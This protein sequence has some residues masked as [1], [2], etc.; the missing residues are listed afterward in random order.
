M[1]PE[2]GQ[3]LAEVKNEPGDEADTADH[4]RATLPQPADQQLSV[5]AN[6]L[7]SPSQLSED[8]N[9][10]QPDRDQSSFANFESAWIMVDG[11][12]SNAGME[13]CPQNAGIRSP[14]AVETDVSVIV[15]NSAQLATNSAASNTSVT[16][17]PSQDVSQLVLSMLR[18]QNIQPASNGTF[19]VV[20]TAVNEQRI[21]KGSGSTT[22]DEVTKLRHL[23][24][25]SNKAKTAL[26]M[27]LR[28]EQA[29]VKYL[30]TEVASQKETIR[31]LSNKISTM[32]YS[33]AGAS[34][35]TDVSNERP[36]M[37][38]LLLHKT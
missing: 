30:L 13:S 31:Q 20:P 12:A 3:A 11:V 37:R 4:M 6:R 1:F 17:P 2:P 16:E 35:S 36:V 32:E 7:S 26:A 8:R 23:L 28:T 38:S 21:K 18:K 33:S 29:K 14:N 25:V 9:A 34:S 22:D 10:F 24:Q 15:L 27:K 5:T 19:S